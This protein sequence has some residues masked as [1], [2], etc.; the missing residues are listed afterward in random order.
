MSHLWQTRSGRLGF[1][2]LQEF[3]ITVTEKLKPGLDR[4]SARED[5]RALLSWKPISVDHRV[6]TAGW[7]LQDSHGLSWW[8]ALI[9][10]AA[11]AADCSYLLTE[12]LQN[13]QVFG[14]LQV[15]NP[16]YTAPG[17]LKPD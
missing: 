16:F 1:Q 14:N 12:D 15:I 13:G 7:H 10:S 4:E 6:F 8:D 5:I 17:T 9:V 2:V 11:Q 3:Y